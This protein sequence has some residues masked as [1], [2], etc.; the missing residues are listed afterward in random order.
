MTLDEEIRRGHEAARIMSDPL[1]V[2]AFKAMDEH[3]LTA[4]KRCAVADVTT[5]HEL[6]LTMQLVEKLKHHINTHIQTG[7]L[8]KEQKRKDSLADRVKGAIRRVM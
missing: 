6:V 2:D 4:M 1:L 5:Q 3:I 7:E 8:A